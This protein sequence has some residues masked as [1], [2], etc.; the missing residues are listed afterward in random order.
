MDIRTKTNHEARMA[1]VIG[2]LYLVIIIAWAYRNGALGIPR[3]DDGFYLRTAFHF[4][5]TGDFV[6][7]SSYPMLFGQVLIS[8]PVIKIF[9]ESIAALQVFWASVAVLSLVV[10]YLLFREFLSSLHSAICVFALALGPIFANLSLSYMTDLPSFS[11]QVFGMFCMSKALSA[12]QK[13]FAWM[14]AALLL[15]A[16]AFTI[17]QNSVFML[18]SFL[19]VLLVN[20]NK[21][22]YAK[23]VAALLSLVIAGLAL[24]YLWRSGLA[25]FGEFA[26][27][28]TK[29]RNPVELVGK[30]FLQSGMTYGIYLIPLVLITSPIQILK[31]FSKKSLYFSLGG[32]LLIAASF[33]VIKPKPAG[34]Y[35]S[36]FVAY[37]A[38]QS[39]SSNDIIYAWEW[40]LL[41][42]IGLICTVAFVIVCGR[43]FVLRRFSPEFKNSSFMVVGAS[44]F[45]LFAFQVVAFGG[46]GFDRYGILL[47]PLAGAFY[48]KCANDQKILTSRFKAASLAYCIIVL[49][50]GVRAF[51]AST[52][53][54]GAGW[55][56]AQQQIEAGSDPLTI[57]GGYSWF[58]FHQTNFETVEIDKFALWFKFR[59][60]SPSLTM[61]EK[62]IID[63]ICYVT[64][65]GDPDTNSKARELEV[66]GL[67]GWKAYFEL[68]KIGGC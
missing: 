40:Q 25:E 26:I 34:N 42:L 14:T 50:L 59:E 2:G 51:D 20:F 65:I 53:F 33:A 43:W 57:D 30:A 15:I 46:G 27:D 37:Q 8:L 28:T 41:Q 54:D 49:I 22:S 60:S 11:F 32:S 68:Q 61:S 18:V 58:A 39:A 3:N 7:V 56:I 55:E 5:S 1:F 63:Q 12:K 16:I 31:N 9:G 64:R 19:L 21:I 52:N 62:Q 48:L 13:N 17:R 29:F 10:L 23:E 44:L 24:F 36:Q 38:T 66:T 4:A 47:V 67:F 45:L 35:F 6:P